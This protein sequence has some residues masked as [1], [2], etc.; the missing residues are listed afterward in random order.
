MLLK[1][2]VSIR[3]EHDRSQSSHRLASTALHFDIIALICCFCG[4]FFI[5][6]SDIY[7]AFQTF[8]FSSNFAIIDISQSKDEFRKSHIVTAVHLDCSAVRNNPK[9]ATFSYLK[10]DTLRRKTVIL[11]TRDHATI[12]FLSQL[13]SIFEQVGV[14][15]VKVLRSTYS[16]FEEQY[17]YL[18]VSKDIKKKKKKKECAPYLPSQIIAKQLYLCNMRMA[19]KQ[20]VMRCLGI[21]HCVNVTADAPHYFEEQGRIKYMRIAI[22]DRLT[23]DVR[24]RFES[25]N[26]FIDTALSEHGVVLVHCRMGRSSSASIVIAYVI[27]KLGLSAEEAM[28]YVKQRRYVINPNESFVRQLQLFA[29]TKKY[30]SD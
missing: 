25:A 15:S 2:F 28:S 11:Y 6:C 8:R 29:E 4:R 27:H 30:Q 7:D 1:V 22:E 13:Q 19:S 18:C 14:E 26:A 12:P 16:V 21:T 9:Q 23:E 10:P 5:S 20:R 17:P 3:I 24:S